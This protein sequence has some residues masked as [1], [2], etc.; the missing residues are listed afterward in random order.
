MATEQCPN[1]GERLPTVVDAFC[2]YCRESLDKPPPPADPPRAWQPVAS[3]FASQP[4][5]KVIVDVP[6][7]LPNLCVLCGVKAQQFIRF[8]FQRDHLVKKTLLR[9]AIGGIFGR[10]VANEAF[11]ERPVDLPLPVCGRHVDDARLDGI[12]G[13]PVDGRQVA[14]AG[15]HPAFVT[16]VSELSRIRWA[17]LARRMSEAENRHKNPL[18]EGN[19]G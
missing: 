5:G 9:H 6:S 13:T 2:P 16:A 14:I 3:S 1:C 12:T 15:I 19:D 7:D 4:A 11:D 8:R 18:E 10:L 17:D